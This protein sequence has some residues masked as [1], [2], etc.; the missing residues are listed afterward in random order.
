MKKK[1]GKNLIVCL[2][3][4]VGIG[5]AQEK[6][7]TIYPYGGAPDSSRFDDQ[8][9]E[10]IPLNFKTAN[11]NSVQFD[12]LADFT[13]AQFQS[14][15]DFR[16]AQFDSLADFRDAEFKE[17]VYFNKAYFYNKI[18]FRNAHIDSVADFSLAIIGDT[19]FV[20]IINSG[21]LQKYDFMRAKLG[22]KGAKIVLCGP[23]DLK[24]QREKFRNIVIWDKLD[25]FSKRDIISTL[26]DVSFK[27]D[28][29]KNERFELDYIF[30][31][32]IMYQVRSTVYGENKWYEFHLWPKW[33]IKGFF[34]NITMGLG[35]R[36]FR[37]LYW[38][39]VVVIGYMIYFL[40]KF[41]EKITNYIA[42]DEKKRVSKKDDSVSKFYQFM[43]T[44][45]NCLYFSSMIF[46][47]FRLKKDILNYFDP[48]EK[49]IIA[50]E[51]FVGLLIYISFLT[52]SKSGSILH[53]LKS[54]FVG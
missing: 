13:W 43:G 2:L 28:K 31:K 27:E 52:F 8:W 7:P 4:F 35:Y 51:W 21:E 3:L 18:D 46:F 11:F 26:K 49:F 29:Y 12:S 53:T 19:V 47:T 42:K 5:F 32:S 10:R 44:L 37:L 41:P 23:V 50:S 17:K 16:S 15:V 9:M 22:A 25:Y 20:G 45:I 14:Q 54:L 24:I 38:V 39:L 33:I 1:I 36:P 6:N 48:K 40:I 30:E 34:Y